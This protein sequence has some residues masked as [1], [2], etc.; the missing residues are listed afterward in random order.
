MTDGTGT[1]DYD[2]DAA[3]DTTSEAL[4]AAGGSGLSNKTISF[5]YLA[6]GELSL[7]K[8]PGYR[9]VSNPEAT[10]KYDTRGDMSSV[11]DWT[12]NKIAFSYDK[13]G[14][15]TTQKNGESTATPTGTSKTAFT[16]DAAN[17]ITSVATTPKHLTT[18]AATRYSYSFAMTAT[19]GGSENADGEVTATKE[20]VKTGCG[21]THSSST[22]NFTYDIAGQVTYGAT[23]SGAA[24]YAY[25]PAG[26]ATKTSRLVSSAWTAFTQTVD[27]AG[28][29]KSQTTGTTTTHFTYDTIGA[30]TTSVIGTVSTGYS[31]DQLGEM[32]SAGTT[33]DHSTYAYDGNGALAALKPHGASSPDQFVW[34]DP[35]GSLTL[36][37]S[38]GADYFIYG[39]STTP[40]EQYGI[41]TPPPSPNPT[42]LNFGAEDGL[43]SMAVTN[44]AG[45]V[46]S[47]TL[48][49]PYGQRL[50]ATTPGSV[51]GYAGQF[52]DT[53]GPSPSGFVDLRA[54]WYSPTTANF[55]RPDPLVTKT[56]QP[57]EYANDDPV[58]V[59]DP[60]GLCG[61]TAAKL[62]NS[63]FGDLSTYLALAGLLVGLGAALAV[64]IDPFDVVF[65]LPALLDTAGD[66]TG[67]AG[68]VTLSTSP[69]GFA[70]G[71][72]GVEAASVATSAGVDV[73][74]IGGSAH[75]TWSTSVKW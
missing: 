28:E 33:T 49:G 8:Y 12:S 69:L 2:Y 10:Y 43:S 52:S 22:T 18:C 7:V 35:T 17:E 72:K 61:C 11:T 29:V 65:V 70:V 4:T 15:L 6:P 74:T 60:T 40:V 66:L 21:A 34:A 32:T 20:V 42:F 23:G 48:F 55:T 47:L 36:L 9:S 31:Y 56:H 3:G 73:D 24:Q 75:G 57:Y 71:K 19:G 39:P 41:A 63:A 59:G 27:T 13:D 45:K 38:D 51:F 58:N 1:T 53:S 46:V 67:L 54:R 30:R 68:F 5:T 16:F 44:T 14:N 50:S 62:L 25:N 37:Y 26:E 64:A